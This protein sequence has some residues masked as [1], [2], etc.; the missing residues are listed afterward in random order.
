MC[1]D[2][3]RQVACASEFGIVVLRDG[4]VVIQTS[5]NDALRSMI[6]DVDCAGCVVYLAWEPDDYVQY[7]LRAASKLVTPTRIIT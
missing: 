2:N 5:G 1:C 3:W 6:H 7:V 4:N